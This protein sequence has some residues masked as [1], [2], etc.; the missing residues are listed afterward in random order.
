M[1][2]QQITVAARFIF[3]WYDWGVL[4]FTFIVVVLI[5]WVFY[6]ARQRRRPATNWQLLV[7]LPALLILPSLLMRINSASMLT[8]PHLLEPFFYLG[9]LGALVCIV[10][11]IGYALTSGQAPAAAPAPPPPR[12]EAPRPTERAAPTVREARP[13]RKAPTAN[14]MLYVQ[15]GP[16]AGTDYRLNL[17]N[18]TIGRGRENDIWIDHPE[19]SGQHAM[20]KEERG[21]FTLHDRGSTNGTFLNGELLRTPVTLEDGDEIGLGQAVTLIFK[22]FS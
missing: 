13:P 8:S 21:R 3:W 19:V 16:R 4:L 10:A 17:G 15:S 20:V 11:A 9:L 22:T 1:F 7:A 6:S 18:T 5:G 2:P 14:A 12:R